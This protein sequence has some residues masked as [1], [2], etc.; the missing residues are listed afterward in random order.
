MPRYDPQ[1]G[2]WSFQNGDLENAEDWKWILL[3]LGVIA[4]FCAVT[5]GAIALVFF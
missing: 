5:I 1:T 3:V 4:A 2:R